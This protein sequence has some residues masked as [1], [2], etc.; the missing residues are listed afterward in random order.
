MSE[1]IF[2]FVFYLILAMGFISLVWLRKGL[3]GITDKVIRRLFIYLLLLTLVCFMYAGWKFVWVQN[4]YTN[5][6]ITAFVDAIIIT[7]LFALIS[8]AALCAKQIGELYGFKV[9]EVR[10]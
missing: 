9:S 1:L 7:T 5:L 2:I 4:I 10:K 3:I 6:W 8:G